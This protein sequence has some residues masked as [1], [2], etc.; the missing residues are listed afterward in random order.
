MRERPEEWDIDPMR[1]HGPNMVS[2]EIV[3]GIQWI[4]LIRAYLLP[5]NMDHLP[6]LEEALNEFLGI[7]PIFMGDMN[8]DVGHMGNP[9]EQQVADF[10]RKHLR[11][12][13]K[14]TWWQS[15]QGKLLCFWYKYILGS[16]HQLLKTVGIRDLRKFSSNHFAPGA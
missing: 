4:T 9:W 16:Y 1:F 3:T 8:T 10:F 7:D 5:A 6:D 2:C 13:L 11:F 15:H 12:R 14:Q